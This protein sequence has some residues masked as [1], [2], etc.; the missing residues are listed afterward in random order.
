MRTHAEQHDRQVAGLPRDCGVAGDRFLAVCPGRIFAHLCDQI[1]PP[2]CSCTRQSAV[3]GHPR[4]GE[5]TLQAQR[6]RFAMILP[7][8]LHGEHVSPY[9]S[10]ICRGT[11]AFPGRGDGPEGP[12]YVSSA[13]EWTLD[14][15]FVPAATRPERLSNRGR[16]PRPSECR[17]GRGL[18][19]A[20]APRPLRP[21]THAG[22]RAPFPAPSARPK[23]VASEPGR[24]SPAAVAAAGPL[25]PSPQPFPTTR[26]GQRPAVQQPRGRRFPLPPGDAPRHESRKSAGSLGSFSGWDFLSFRSRETAR[27]PPDPSQECNRRSNSH[28]NLAFFSP[29]SPSAC[30]DRRNRQ[31]PRRRTYGRKA[32]FN[33][34]LRVQPVVWTS[35]GIRGG[36]AT[37]SRRGHCQTSGPAQIKVSIFTG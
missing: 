2:S 32:S 1:E 12:S 30:V 31:R 19:V 24:S 14:R 36:M 26:G 34:H 29:V 23:T 7:R 10:A 13:T 33:M 11:T 17:T 28:H 5:R 15:C 37:C 21:R 22:G 27:P 20:G 18:P 16:A 4:A 3:F 8:P 35:P 6:L 25:P 9:N